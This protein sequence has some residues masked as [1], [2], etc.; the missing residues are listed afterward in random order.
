MFYSSI[1]GTTS[2][3]YSS[4]GSGYFSAGKCPTEAYQTLMNF[5]TNGFMLPT[6]ST[7][8]PS[9]STYYCDYAWY[10]NSQVDVALFGGN[11][12]DGLPVGA[13]A[14]DLLA[15]AS[16]SWWH[17]GASLSACLRNSDHRKYAKNKEPFIGSL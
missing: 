13:F 16:D 14:L 2:T 1:D 10:N 15:A 11:S 4:S 6:A 12:N 17:C 3:A 5:N 9:S 8:T 7:Y